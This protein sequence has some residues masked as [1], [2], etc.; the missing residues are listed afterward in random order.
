MEEVEKSER[1]LKNCRNKGSKRGRAK[2][3]AQRVNTI[4]ATGED[5]D[6]ASLTFKWENNAADTFRAF[7]YTLWRLDRL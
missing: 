3:T 7:G 2:N 4:K 5:A 6:K 1:L